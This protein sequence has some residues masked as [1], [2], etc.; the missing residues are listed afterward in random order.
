METSRVLD[1]TQA[2]SAKRSGQGA[3]AADLAALYDTHSGPLYRYLVSLLGH[4][5]DAEDALQEV[6]L[7]VMRRGGLRGIR[8]ARAYLLQ[9]ARRQAL[10]ALRGRRGRERQAAAAEISWIDTDA[11][12]GDGRE[13]ALDIDR[14]LRQLPLEQREA[15]GLKLGEEL[16]LREIAEA[17][18]I[19]L[20]T[21]ASRCRRAL[22]RLRELLKEGSDDDR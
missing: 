10:Q 15:V 14:A 22:V 19:P 12:L 1:G 7:G 21:A 6:F 2:R 13:L 17:L 8:D 3:E 20:S 5:S 4:V 16:T 9:A 18:D 11:A